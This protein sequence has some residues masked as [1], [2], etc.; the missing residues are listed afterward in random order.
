MWLDYFPIVHA[1]LDNVRAL[2]RLHGLAFPVPNSTLVMLEA[3]YTSARD[4][5]AAESLLSSATPSPHAPPEV[6]AASA[7]L[8]LRLQG[9]QSVW[10]CFRAEC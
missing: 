1:M 6:Q 2:L 3:Q 7:R 9:A 5:S 4:A 8:L 10:L